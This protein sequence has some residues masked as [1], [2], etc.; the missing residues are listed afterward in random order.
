MSKT[1]DKKIVELGMENSDLINKAA[2]S[3]KALGGLQDGINKVKGKDLSSVSSGLK[4]IGSGASDAASKSNLLGE[5]ADTIKNR[6]SAM[7]IA[8]MTVIT[9]L[10]NRV[11]NAGMQLAQS[12]TTAPIKEGFDM[13]ENKMKAIQ[14]ILSNTQG[15]SNLQDVQKALSS[16][17]DYANKT[18]YSFQ[19]MTTN[20][21]TFTAAGVD[22]NTAKDAIQGIGNLAA[23]SGSSTEQAG[24]AMY[25]LSQAIASGSV[26]LQDWNSVVNAGMGGAKFQ[27]ALKKNGVEMGKNIKMTDNFRDSLQ[28][29]WLTTDVLMK[30]LRQFK[31]DKS[32]QVAATQAK[33]FSAAMDT[34]NDEL[35]SGWAQTWELLIGDYTQAPKLWTAFANGMSNAINNAAQ[36]RN[37]FIKGFNDLGGRAQVL[38]LLIN[39]FHLVANA[40]D[41][42]KKGFKDVFPS[43]TAQQLYSFVTG[44]NIFVAKAM[45]ATDAIDALR[46]ISRGFFTIIKLGAEVVVGFAKVL[47]ALIPDNLISDIIKILGA[48]GNFIYQMGK[49]NV[50]AKD[51][52]N[53][54]DNLH[55]AVNNFYDGIEKAFKSLGGFLGI[56]EKVGQAIAKWITPYFKIAAKAV[57]DFVGSFTFGDLLGAG[58]VGGL[59][60]IGSKL[61]AV[62]QIFSDFFDK[63]TSFIDKGAETAKS[64][65][66]LKDSLKGLTTAFKATTLVEIAA[67]VVT[68]AIAMKMLSGL[69]LPQIGK[70]LESIGVAMF[71]LTKTLQAISKFDFSTGAFK[72]ATLMIALSTSIVELA[73]ATTT[74]SKIDP[75]KLA[76][77][78]IG[79]AATIGIL[80]KGM[81]S[82]TGFVPVA[83]G[84]S[85]GIIALATATIILVDAVD[86]LS[87]IKGTSLVKA[88]MSLG[89]VFSEIGLYARIVNG[90]HIN[91][92]TSVGIIALAASTELLINAISKLAKINSTSLSKALLSTGVIFGEIAL[93]TLAVNRVKISPTTIVTMLAL[94]E[95]TKMLVS[96]ISKMATINST[97]LG[98]ALLALGAIFGEIVAFSAGMSH[99]KLGST[100]PQLI[101]LAIAI[102]QL[103]QPIQ[104]F[105]QM[106]L[107]QIGKGLTTLG[108]ALAIIVAAMAGSAGALAGAASIMITAVAINALVVPL[109]ALGNMS[110][111]QIGTA[112]LAL[113][114]AFT[115]MAVASHLIGVSGAVGLL[116]FAAAMGAVGLAVMAIGIAATAFVGFL[117]LMSTMSSNT[118]D[119]ISK[120]FNTLLKNFGNSIPLLTA[121]V[122]KAI[123]AFLNA[124]EKIIPKFVDVG[125]D[126]LM[127]LLR[128][129]SENIYEIVTLALQIIAQFIEGLAEGLPKVLKAGTDFIIAFIDGLA[130]NIRKNGPRLL[131]AIGSL[132]ESILEIMVKGLVGV[133]DTLL[134][135]IPG[136]HDMLKSAGDSAVKGLREGFHVKGIGEDGGQE[137]VDGIS[138]KQQA[139][140]DAGV[141]LKH[142]AEDGTAEGTTGDGTTSVMYNHGQQA[143]AQYGL[144]VQSNEPD[145]QTHGQKLAAGVQTGADNPDAMKNTGA[146]VSSAYNYGL[147]S[148]APG[149]F[150]A[151]NQLANNANTGSKTDLSGNGAAGGSSF[152][153]GIS[154]QSGGTSAAA[155]LLKNNAHAGTQVDLSGNG[156]AGGSSFSGGLSNQAEGAHGAG[157]HV[158]HRAKDGMDVDT[159]DKGRNAGQGF[160]NGIG[161]MLGGVWDA[162]WKLGQEALSA[163]GRSIKSHSPSRETMKYGGYFSQGFANGIKNFSGGAVNAATS[164]G[165]QSVTALKSVGAQVNSLINDSMNLQP[166]I[167]PV[168]DLSNI[169]ATPINLT[170][171]ITSA[172]MLGNDPSVTATQVTNNITFGDFKFDVQ[173]KDTATAQELVDM[174]HSKFQ[175][176]LAQEVR[177]VK[178]V[179]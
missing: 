123:M 26:K 78:L 118:L 57:S 100:G 5:A 95:T 176:W 97:S 173:A 3:T 134:G 36:A 77:G 178:E 16:L 151:G 55:T 165:Q 140:Y 154:S 33:T 130:N 112:L 42:V 67:A 82:L 88:V 170:A 117:D 85:V 115:I 14:V 157:Q 58:G 43:V 53:G 49:G 80:V 45:G 81:N 51:F 160:I 27:D 9:N 168:L 52:S 21:G 66:I 99:M 119:H 23:A 38:N 65:D 125:L 72:A 152:S 62:K 98:K 59:I 15:K 63:I 4:G 56:L 171:S 11:V 174:I 40:I 103:V 22:L 158:A 86:K 46:D 24:M 111:M 61:G 141:V 104:K 54:L 32:M 108:L 120:S 167:V 127:S 161:D 35:K 6:F 74:L 84:A 96:S 69:S 179:R 122:V 155:N 145:A 71:A 109:K 89:I 73:K 92:S 25:Q 75:D 148:N 60:L 20:M 129:V 150:S 39:T 17:N 137:F 41:E 19:D 162:A 87:K 156:A 50:G 107:N 70:G 13:Y 94:S 139:A 164:L 76:S 30:T 169:N 44:L 124:L 79:L 37:N 153:S 147:K 146:G 116:A 64:L 172:R 121:V 90:V 102:Q 68:L 175:G 83:K 93:F 177:K 143:G 135:W 159:R 110:L 48:I 91:P 132:I 47:G 144:G 7:G 101:L 128:G 163:I 31:D 133:L 114:G 105:G 142:K 28:N 113:A 12:F 2:Q 126:I 149:A 29:G 18:V 166:H 138:S 136:A 10:T 34:A 1:V 131:Q 106:S 8:T